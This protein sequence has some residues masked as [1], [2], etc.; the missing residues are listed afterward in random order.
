MKKELEGWLVV[1]GLVI[2]PL[3]MIVAIMSGAIR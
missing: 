1:L 2:V 3:A